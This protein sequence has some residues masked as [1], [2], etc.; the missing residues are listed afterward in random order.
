MATEQLIQAH[1]KEKNGF[2][3]SFL[4]SSGWPYTAT[5]SRSSLSS[6]ISIL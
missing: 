1:P 4:W 3:M 6:H 5:I 2:I